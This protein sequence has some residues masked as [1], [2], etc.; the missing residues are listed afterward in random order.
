[1]SNTID[2]RGYKV[3]DALD[4]LEA[5]LDKASLANLTPVYVIHGNGTGAL[6]TYVRDYVSTSPYV[7]KFRPGEQSEGGDG[8]TVIDI[9]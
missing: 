9:N 1:M 4:T 2:L 5:Y 8:V 3:D 7:A 6:R